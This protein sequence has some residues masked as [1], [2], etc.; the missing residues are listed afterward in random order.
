[1]TPV[2]IGDVIARVSNATMPDDEADRLIEEAAQSA[3]DQ[4]RERCRLGRR[5]AQDIFERQQGIDAEQQQE[6]ENNLA[7]IKAEG[8][9]SKRPVRRI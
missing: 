1:M 7:R 4:V 8:E 6:A 5:N 9:A 3:A 2:D